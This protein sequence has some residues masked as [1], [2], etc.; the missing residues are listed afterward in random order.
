MSIW[1]DLE[2]AE[3]EERDAYSHKM[4]AMQ[5]IRK[6]VENKLELPPKIFVR[7]DI[8]AETH[9]VTLYLYK[10]QGPHCSY[11]SPYEVSLEEWLRFA[12]VLGTQD[13]CMPEIAGAY[14]KV[15]VRGI[16]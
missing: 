2:V 3:R 10:E 11:I 9:E 13:I 8:D 6:W 14:T 15:V 4:E 7:I 5:K 12:S 16:K 1:N